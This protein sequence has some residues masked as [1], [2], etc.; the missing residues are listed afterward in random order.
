MELQSSGYRRLARLGGTRAQ[1]AGSYEKEE[2][3]KPREDF[4]RLSS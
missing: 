2:E 1:Q 3:R 4:M